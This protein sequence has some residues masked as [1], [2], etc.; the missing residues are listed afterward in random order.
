MRCILQALVAM[1]SK[2]IVHRDLKP[3]NLLFK[4]AI[5][6]ELINCRD[7]SIESLKIVD[8]GLSASTK[9]GPLTMRCGSPGYVAPEIL[10]DK[11]YSCKADIFSAG[12]ILYIL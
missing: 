10:E 9:N 7:K 3:E 6:D 12:I 4:Y 2:N 11:G 8:F 5:L 1:H